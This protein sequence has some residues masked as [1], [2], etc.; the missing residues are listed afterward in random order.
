MVD[1]RPQSGREEKRART[2]DYERQGG[3]DRHCSASG[4]ER[5]PVKAP[6]AIDISNR[7]EQ[8]EQARCQNQ[9]LAHREAARMAP[10]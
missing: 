5:Q 6:D 10:K 4:D 7:I 1:M 9:I 3:V 8:A 2:K